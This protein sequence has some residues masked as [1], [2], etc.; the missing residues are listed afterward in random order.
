MDIKFVAFESLGVR[1]QATFVQ[2]E[3]ANVFIDPSAALAP[4]RFGLPPHILEAEKLL[5]IFNRI[6]S[7]LRDS[8]ILIFTHYHYDHHDPGKFLD[9][10]LYRNKIVFLKDP[11]SYINASQRIRASVFLRVLK[12]KVKDVR[13]ADGRREILN[14]TTIRFSSPLPHGESD[15][16]GYVVG[17]CVEDGNEALM[18]TSDIEGGPAEAHRELLDFC[19]ARVAVID[20]PPTYL[21]GYK[22]S[23]ESL[24]SSIDF[25]S[26]LI[27]IRS[28]EV[29]ILDHHLCRDLDYAKK[30]I[31][32]IEKAKNMGVKIKTAAESMGL[33][34]LFLEAIRRELYMKRPENGLELLKSMYRGHRKIENVEHLFAED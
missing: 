16:L 1:S 7:L 11:Q 32:L 28:I 3:D 33:E 20:G 17:V 30:L 26:R 12:D 8:D 24:R 29:V 22:Y 13:V 5:D 10:E 15:R 31:E 18:Y 23:I 6:E 27:E 14:R 34:P 9:P 4:R 25:L 19:R 2:T 21:V